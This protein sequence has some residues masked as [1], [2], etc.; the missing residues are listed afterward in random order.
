V[1]NK[2]LSATDGVD[3]VSSTGGDA[4]SAWVAALF[5]FFRISNAFSSRAFSGVNAGSLDV[6]VI[7]DNGDLTEAPE[8]VAGLPPLV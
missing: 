5:C 7:G 3:R 2:R 1:S 6:A 4:Y 8:L